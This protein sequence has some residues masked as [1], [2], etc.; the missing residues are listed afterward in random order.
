MM[1]GRRGG[2]RWIAAL[3]A[4]GLLS[5]CST[6]GDSGTA[7]TDQPAVSPL[8]DS[9]VDSSSLPPIGASDGSVQVANADPAAPQAG[10][11]NQPGMPVIPG[12]TGTSTTTAGTGTTPAPAQG[13]FVSLSDVSKTPGGPGRDLAGGVSVDKLLGGWT[14]TSGDTTCRLNLTYSSAGAPD[15][16]RASAPGCAIQTLATVSSW[17]LV[18]TQLQLFNDGN[19]LVGALLLSNNRFIGTLS[20]GQSISMAG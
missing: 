1:D 19:A 6:M 16:Y 17:A 9:A 8:A 12:D 2:G 20:G 14:V 5:G 4:A 15:H 10:Q 7:S 13:A 11:P 18:G 3:L